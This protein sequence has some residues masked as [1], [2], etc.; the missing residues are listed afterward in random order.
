MGSQGSTLGFRTYTF[1]E[2]K[3]K[4]KNLV[5]FFLGK[6]LVAAFK[7]E[8]R[9]FSFWS[10]PFFLSCYSKSLQWSTYSWLHAEMLE[11]MR[12]IMDAGMHHYLRNSLIPLKNL[13]DLRSRHDLR[14]E[15][16][17]WRQ[18]LKKVNHRCSWEIG[19]RRT[20]GDK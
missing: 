15:I 18:G 16:A 14:F 5:F 10:E 17:T 11:G 2:K 4:K 1:Y 13:V 9:K 6:K 19:K 7:F 12:W 20:F 8:K 3:K